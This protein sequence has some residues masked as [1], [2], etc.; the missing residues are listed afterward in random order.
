MGM[1]N[2]TAV[3]YFYSLYFT[4]YL[5]ILEKKRESGIKKAKGKTKIK[6]EEHDNSL[7]SRKT[8]YVNKEILKYRHFPTVNKQ[9]HQEKEEKKIK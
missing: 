3:L 5:F 7:K 9:E 2:C 8:Q 6:H 1:C 4:T